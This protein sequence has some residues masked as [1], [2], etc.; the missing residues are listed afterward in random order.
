M[1]R[2]SYE[3]ASKRIKKR[4]A[5]V[6]FFLSYGQCRTFEHLPWRNLSQ[7][8]WSP[9]PPSLFKAKSQLASPSRSYALSRKGTIITRLA[10]H[11]QDVSYNF[12]AR[13]L[14]MGR[15][16]F[17]PYGQ[18]RNFGPSPKGTLRS[19]FRVLQFFGTP[20]PLWGVSSFFCPM[21]SVVPSAPPLK[22]PSVATSASCGAYARRVL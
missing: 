6:A 21:G 3:F 11:T 17:L 12:S 5:R 16:F 20:L 10:G 8:V 7:S 4:S 15:F 18:C 22:G 14:H 13:P 9:R 19:Y 1:C 2:N